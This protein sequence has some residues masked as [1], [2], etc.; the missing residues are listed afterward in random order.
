[1]V[2]TRSVYRVLVGTPDGK[3]PLGKSRRRWEVDMK[4]DLQE[5]G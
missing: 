3:R 2:Y 5:L 1:M 4:V